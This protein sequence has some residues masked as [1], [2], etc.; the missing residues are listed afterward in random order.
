MRLCYCYLRIVH[1]IMEVTIDD[2]DDDDD[3]TQLQNAQT[4][5]DKLV[6]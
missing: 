4:R 5:A 1:F 3:T 2:D 6:A